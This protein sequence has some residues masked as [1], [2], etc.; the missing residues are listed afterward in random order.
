[1]GLADP[2]MYSFGWITSELA[3]LDVESA[4][5]E[6]VRRVNKDIRPVLPVEK[7]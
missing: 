4:A 6:F 7:A 5:R 2:P 1:M 3:A